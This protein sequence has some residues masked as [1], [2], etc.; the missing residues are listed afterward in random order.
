MRLKSNL[1]GKMG[2]AVAVILLLAVAAATVLN[3]LRFEQIYG[4]FIQRRLAVV[5]ADI[6]RDVVVGLDFGLPLNGIENLP[7]ILARHRDSDSGIVTITVHDCRGNAVAVA[8][9]PEGGSAPWRSHVGEVAWRLFSDDGI[10]AGRRVEDA[11]GQCAGGISVTYD[12][13]E[14]RATL[15]RTHGQ[16]YL[17]GALALLVICPA[18]LAIHLLLRRRVAVFGALEKDVTHLIRDFGVDRA[19]EAGGRLLPSRTDPDKALIEAYRHARPALADGLRKA[20]NGE[21]RSG[22]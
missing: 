18:L 14:Y 6:R 12:A 2:V 8:G 4:Q 3:A 5:L 21:G 7:A 19:A 16:L 22:S 15:S 11:F 10:A 13:D 9:Q 1:A 20:A 17:R